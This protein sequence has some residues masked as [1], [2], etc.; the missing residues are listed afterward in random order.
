MAYR[1][2]EQRRQYMYNWAQRTKYDSCEC[3]NRKAKKSRR[4]AQCR[5]QDY[6][7]PR[8]VTDAEIAWI[9]G[10]LEGE[11]CWTRHNGRTDWSVSVRM[12][13]Q[14]IIERLQAI[15]GIGRLTFDGTPSK[16]A[17]KPAW[18]W[19][20]YARPHREWLTVKVWP[21][22]GVRRRTRICELWPDFQAPQTFSGDVSALQAG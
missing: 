7:P 1:N 14:D 11:G 2:S 12:T 17:R 19:G 6:P 4:C 5:S 20:V 10:I 9:A 16:R 13:D 15:T 8:Q 22:L 3:G 21:W 18:V